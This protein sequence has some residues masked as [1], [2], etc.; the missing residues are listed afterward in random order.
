MAVRKRP[1]ASHLS[2]AAVRGLVQNFDGHIILPDD[3]RYA[4]ARRV[5]NHVVNKFPQL[6]AQCGSRDD[7][8]R[9]IEFACQ[10]DLLIAVRSGGHSFAGYGVCDNG[11]V[12]DLTLMK[13]AQ[14]DPGAALV[15][16]EPG[17]HAHELDYITQAFKM[18]VPLGS[19]P[20]VGVAGYA[21]GGGEGSLTPKFGYGCDSIKQVEIITADTQTLIARPD[22]HE[23]LFWALR[24]AGA[25][26]GIAV[27]LE[28]QMHPIE[29]VLSGHLQYPL[30]QAPKVLRFIKDYAASIPDDLYLIVAVLP[31][32]GERMLDVS[33]VWPDDPKRGEKILRP[34]R[35]FLRPFKDTIAVRE[36]L[37]EQRAG[38]DTPEGDEPYSSCRRG[39]H[40]EQITPEL[41]ET[42][43]DY[44]SNSPSEASG[45][46]MVYWHGPWSAQAHDN[47]FGFR[48]TGYEFWIHSYWQPMELRRK[49]QTW[50]ENFYAAMVPFSS[51]AVYI[52]ALED[53][54]QE[55]TRAAYGAQYGRLQIIKH[56]YDPTNRFRVNQNIE[57]RADAG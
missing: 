56:R 29:R 38:S 4:S 48:R 36:Y 32:P 11:I 35:N 53:E 28:L 52:N 33:V 24:G 7:I 13:R 15:R 16:I 46:T 50:V 55:R 2:Q 39:G 37:D 42:I 27:S 6:I 54:G 44:A 23:D 22:E 1:V 14:V 8:K 9:T 57:P 10:Q 49:A 25:N 5:W 17:V 41:I 20:G 45:I 40:F 31:H 43:V 34:L 30:R 51:G 26:F 21:L 3:R 47:A 12:I 18:A 19:C